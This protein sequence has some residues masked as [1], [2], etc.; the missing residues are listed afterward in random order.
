MA[1]K[2]KK[3]DVSFTPTGTGIRNDGKIERST[4]L[5]GTTNKKHKTLGFSEEDLTDM[6]RLMYLQRRFEE[7]AMQ[8]YQK[9]K[10][11]PDLKLSDLWE[12]YNL[13]ME[14]AAIYPLR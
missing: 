10:F 12:I 14:W 3:Q 7:R 8:M 2:K 1:K 6:Y 11:F 5:P 13:D 4:D 9:G